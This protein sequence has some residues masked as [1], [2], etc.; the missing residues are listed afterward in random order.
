MSELLLHISPF[1]C[2][3]SATFEGNHIA[4]PDRLRF[5]ASQG[6]AAG[7]RGAQRHKAQQNPQQGQHR[8]PGHPAA[9]KAAK[10]AQRGITSSAS[11]RLPA[12]LG[13]NISSEP[14]TGRE[15]TQLTAEE[16]YFSRPRLPA[17]Y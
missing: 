15:H 4:L 8:V 13:K 2:Q 6:P 17:E 1:H 7:T 9:A 10:M 11:L 3:E 14:A 16:K 12:H 5:S